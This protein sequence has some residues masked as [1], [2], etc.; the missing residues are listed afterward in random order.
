[1]PFKDQNIWI[2]G[3]SSGMGRELAVQLDGLGANL[4]LSARSHDK[5]EELNNELGKRHKVCQ[6]DVSKKGEVK[7]TLEQI[8]ASYKTLDRVIFMS[9]IYKPDSILDMDIEFASDLVDV[10]LKSLFYLTNAVLPIFN[11]QQSGQIAI[12]GS[13]AGYVG[14]ANGQPYSSTKAAIINFTESLHTESPNIL[15]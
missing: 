3:A 15:M 9:A 1:M 7:S 11:K 13:V 12:C 4:I 6:L 5:L 14:L 8:S 2:I 10:N